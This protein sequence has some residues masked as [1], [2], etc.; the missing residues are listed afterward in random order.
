MFS[1]AAVVLVPQREAVKLL[2]QCLV[3]P[4]QEPRLV[5]LCA[6]LDQ[7]TS[8]TRRPGLDSGSCQVP[9][10]SDVPVL[11][12]KKRQTSFHLVTTFLSFIITLN[13]L[14]VSIV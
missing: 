5:G 11:T 9:R 7:S 6:Q 2:L 13:L 10:V 3:E 4:N 12:G 8:S 14:K 1:S